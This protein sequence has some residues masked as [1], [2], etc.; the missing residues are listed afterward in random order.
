MIAPLFTAASGWIVQRRALALGVLATGNG[1]GTLLLVPFAE[2]LI[3]D[4]GWRDAYVRLAVVDF[5]VIGAV[6]V[7]VRARPSRRPRPPW[8]G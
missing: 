2:R 7:V 8:R 4:H 1:L 3:S 5:V 6:C